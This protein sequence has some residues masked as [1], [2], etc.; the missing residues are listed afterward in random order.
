MF[1]AKFRNSLISPNSPIILPRAS[2]QIDHEGELAVVTVT[3]CK[4]V[5]KE[6][7]DVIRI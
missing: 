2:S 5:A 6:Q 4:V 1:F 3:R 7:K